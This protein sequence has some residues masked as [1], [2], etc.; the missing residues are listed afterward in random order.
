MGVYSKFEQKLVN[1]QSN[2]AKTFLEISLQVLP[3]HF[4]GYTQVILK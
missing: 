2:W 3:K 1:G 4:K